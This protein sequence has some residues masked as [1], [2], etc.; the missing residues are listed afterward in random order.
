MKNE[1]DVTHF[2]QGVSLLVKLAFELSLF[3]EETRP[4]SFGEF[5]MNNVQFAICM[6]NY[7]QCCAREHAQTLKACMA[8]RTL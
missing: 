5:S 6:L 7:A 1:F 2:S 3:V 8:R 4:F